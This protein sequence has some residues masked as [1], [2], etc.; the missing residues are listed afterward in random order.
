MTKDTPE[1]GPRAPID[2]ADDPML[3]PTL[4]SVFLAIGL[5]VPI[6]TIWN[7]EP[8]SLLAQ[9]L[10]CVSGSLLVA[11]S[12]FLS[13]GLLGQARRR[14]PRE[15][16]EFVRRGA[17]P[18]P[19]IPQWI[20]AQIDKGCTGYANIDWRGDW[21]PLIIPLALST[22]AEFLAFRDWAGARGATGALVYQVAGGIFIASAFPLLVAERHYAGQSGRPSSEARPLARLCR[23][24]LAA[25]LALGIAAILFSLGFAWARF[26]ADAVA[27]TIGII[28]AEIILRCAAHIFVPLA[29]LAQR[30]SAAAS[31]AAGLIQLGMPKFGAFTVAVHQQFGIDLSRSW[32]LAFVRRAALPVIA[33]MIVFAWLLTGV[34]A[35]GLGQRAVYEEFGAPVAVFH[36]GLHLHWPWPFGILRPVELGEIHEIPIVLGQN[37]AFEAGAPIEPRTIPI[38]AEGVPPESADRLWDYTHPSEASYLIASNANGKQTFQIVDIDL[39]IVYRVGLSDQAAKAALYNVGAPEDLIR[40]AAGRMLVRHFARYTLADVLGQNRESFVDTFKTQLQSRLDALSA[41]VDIIAVIVEAIHPPA[42]AARAYHRVQAATIQSVAQI[43]LSR[44]DATRVL[45]A[46]EVSSFQARNEAASL[47]A[48]RIDTATIARTLFDGD[49]D[50][51]RSGGEAFLFERWLTH[52]TKGLHTPPIVI[53]DHRLGGQNTP[54]VDLRQLS[55]ATTP[56]IGDGY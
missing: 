28:A 41:G 21:A 33:G 30:R 2:P 10:F 51:Y 53:V 26:I 19:R 9:F 56:A 13:S 22:V 31:A 49:R 7:A 17:K 37:G 12:G 8:G 34:T 50:A 29:P 42:G 54:T 47:A 32:A 25:C 44:A 38:D 43:S 4:G 1:Q 15:R 52:V 48:E 46:A 11:A 5:I 14:G 35:L 36:S 55:G 23:V 24:P 20:R 27:V 3:T 6:A 45:K 18:L 40:V 16:I 39:R